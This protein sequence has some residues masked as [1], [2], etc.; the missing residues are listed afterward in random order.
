[1]LCTFGERYFNERRLRGPIFASDGSRVLWLHSGEQEEQDEQDEQDE[2]EEQEEQEE[3][4]RG[5]AGL[6]GTNIFQPFARRKVPRPMPWLL[7]WLPP[8]HAARRVQAAE[9]APRRRHATA[10]GV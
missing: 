3:E 2:Q 6:D 10:A 1:V 7:K 5:S 4:G 9:V 8:P